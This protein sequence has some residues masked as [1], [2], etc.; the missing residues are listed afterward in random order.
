MKKLLSFLMFLPLATNS[1]IIINE[2]PKP[3]VKEIVKVENDSVFTVH[4]TIYHADISQ[5]D[6]T[7]LITASGFIL[8]SI[9]NFNKRVIAVSRD[10]KKKMK[11]HSKVMI[12]GLY[13]KS[14]NG[15]YRVEDLMGKR[16]NNRIDIL[17]DK[18]TKL[19]RTSFKN[20]QIELI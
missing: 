20:V 1:E 18:D 14:L 12:T 6:S 16:W 4:S 5:C 17:V 8:D 7:P 11:W 13:P 9:R 2:F 19:S 10:L 3:E 15:I